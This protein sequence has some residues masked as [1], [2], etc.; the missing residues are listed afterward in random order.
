MAGQSLTSI[1]LTRL[2]HVNGCGFD[3]LLAFFKSARLNMPRWN[4]LRSKVAVYP[5]DVIGAGRPVALDVVPS[6]RFPQ[7]CCAIKNA[8]KSTVVH[9]TVAEPR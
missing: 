7:N 1:L 9:K 8:P 2:R 6:Q 3:L 4:R 5:R